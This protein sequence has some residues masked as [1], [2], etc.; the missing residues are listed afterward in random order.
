MTEQKEDVKKKTLTIKE[1]TWKR[2]TYMK[3]KEGTDTIDELVN[4]LM[5]SYENGKEIL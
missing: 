1:E 4:Y 3:L 2:L 5:D